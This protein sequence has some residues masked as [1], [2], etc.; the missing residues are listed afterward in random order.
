MVEIILVI[1]AAIILAFLGYFLAK[2]PVD[3]ESGVVNQYLLADE[4]FE[5][6][7]FTGECVDRRAEGW[8]GPAGGG[9]EEGGSATRCLLRRGRHG[10]A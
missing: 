7:W 8:T 1:P 3:E 2:R 10:Q 5:R 4:N 6:N 9:V